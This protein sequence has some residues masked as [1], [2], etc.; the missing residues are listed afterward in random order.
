MCK[1]EMN[2]FSIDSVLYANDT[3][4]LFVF[5]DT[6]S[7]S[8]LDILNSNFSNIRNN[9]G[10]SMIEIENFSILNIENI[11]IE[12]I[13]SDND[14]FFC[15]Y[16]VKNVKIIDLALIKY[17]SESDK[18]IYFLNVENVLMFNIKIFD[19]FSPIYLKNCSFVFI[20]NYHAENSNGAA[21][22]GIYFDSWK[23]LTIKNMNM[24]NIT[25]DLS[26]G[27]LMLIFL[28][29]SSVTIEN[30]RFENCRSIRGSVFYIY[31][32]NEE[33]LELDIRNSDFENNYA[34]EDG[35]VMF[36]DKNTK[37]YQSIITNCN[38]VNNFSSGFSGVFAL[39]HNGYLGIVDSIFRNNT[40]F[41]TAAIYGSFQTSEN[42]L[43][44]TNVTFLE[45]KGNNLL[46]LHSTVFG[47]KFVSQDC[48][49]SKFNL[50]SII[51]S[52]IIWN[53]I[54]SE[55]SHNFRSI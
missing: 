20:E 7:D 38:F 27:C 34:T 48:V 32:P 19:A 18:G 24:K 25:S 47:T 21:N 29:H 44:L 43:G 40:S 37:V 3:S 42:I 39:F 15:I 9:L 14:C 30:S 41:R 11:Q 10:S 49:F 5:K 54:N 52:N 46:F 1:F 33:S 23:N 50:T 6:N 28:E 13:I 51:I 4:G 16:D 55:F 35:S 53:D 36:I 26:G 12:A 17:I 22:G 45:N 8:S 2:N 31:S